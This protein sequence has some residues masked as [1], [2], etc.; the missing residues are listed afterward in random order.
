MEVLE[1]QRV[2]LR[3]FEDNPREVGTVL[4]VEPGVVTVEL[5]EEYRSSDPGYFDDGLREVTPEQIEG[6]AR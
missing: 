5:D 6:L 2:V 1:G 4:E 3:P